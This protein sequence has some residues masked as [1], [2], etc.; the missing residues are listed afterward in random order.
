MPKHYKKKTETVELDGKQVKFKEGAL[1][2]QLKLKKD[3]K[4]TKPM[5]KKI[6]NKENFKLFGRDYKMTP[7]MKKRFNFALTLMK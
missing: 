6:I 2:K 3:E 7:L 5:I 4:L 1:R